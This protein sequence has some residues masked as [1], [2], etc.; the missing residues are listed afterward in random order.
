MKILS[1]EKRTKIVTLLVE[2]M[3]IRA[4]CRV[5]GVAKHTVLKLLVDLGAAC[6]EYHD[7]HVR[8]LRSQRVQCDE[9]W[10]FVGCKDKNILPD[11]EGFGR[12]SIW[13]WTALDA[14]TKL[15]AAYHVGTR[16][17]GCAYEFMTDLERR[18]LRDA[19]ETL[20]RG[21]A[22]CRALFAPAVHRREPHPDHGRP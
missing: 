4:T 16:D 5:T 6:R 17:A 14:D 19:R 18:G 8:N 20:R 13:T 2:G 10:A 15:M 7:A 21:S 11:E 1:T 9:L 22:G 12:G 3:S